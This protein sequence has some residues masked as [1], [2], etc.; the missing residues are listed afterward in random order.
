MFQRLGPQGG[1]VFLQ[2]P[3][4]QSEISGI[5]SRSDIQPVQVSY[6]SDPE[7]KGLIMRRDAAL[8]DGLFDREDDVTEVSRDSSRSLAI[9]V[10]LKYISLI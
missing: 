6:D 5:T 4:E 8:F 9:S 7:L 3:T 2:P 10:I 1:V